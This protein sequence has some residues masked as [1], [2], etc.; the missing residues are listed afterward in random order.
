MAAAAAAGRRKNKAAG[1]EK[2]I[3]GWFKTTTIIH[4]LVLPP[5]RSVRL[6]QTMSFPVHHPTTGAEGMPTFARSGFRPSVY[7][8]HLF[9]PVLNRF[10]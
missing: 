8:I 7:T 1:G 6:A 3:F 5:G 4:L 10:V 2:H 9:S